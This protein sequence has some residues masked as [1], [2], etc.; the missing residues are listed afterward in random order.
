MM[1]D[2]FI[3]HSKYIWPNPSPTE[4]HSST[5]RH[6]K[7]AR[8]LHKAFA[9]AR[10]MVWLLFSI[11]NSFSPQ[12]PFSHPAFPARPCRDASAQ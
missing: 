9:A 5:A 6:S 12:A 2:L 8:D 10:A 3:N 11:S 4:L 1:T 7:G